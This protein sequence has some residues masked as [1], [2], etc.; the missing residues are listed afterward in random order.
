MAS[1]S[2]FVNWHSLSIEEKLEALRTALAPH[3]VTHVPFVRTHGHASAPAQAYSGD[4]G[5]DLAACEE[6]DIEDGDQV[7]VPT[8]V[9]AALPEGTWGL[10]MPRSG[11]LREG[12]LLVIP[13]VIDA[14]Y[15]GELKV[16]TKAV[17][18]QGIIEKVTVGFRLA[19]IIVVPLLPRLEWVE[20]QSLPD[21][22]RG[23][24][25]FGSSGHMARFF[26]RRADA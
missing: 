2:D 11:V 6:V 19:Q 9:H 25:G 24:K 14:G 16:L 13:G 1:G 5:F 18:G 26:E 10:I 4:A 8:G 23:E 12:R 17:N 22:S 20:R 15:R 3:L 7:D 21:G